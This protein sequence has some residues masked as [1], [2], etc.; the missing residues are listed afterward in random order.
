MRK[1]KINVLLRY[2]NCVCAKLHKARNTMNEADII[3]YKAIKMKLLFLES[4]IYKDYARHDIST[5][6]DF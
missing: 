5:L 4:A 2:Y 6:I 1:V 3:K